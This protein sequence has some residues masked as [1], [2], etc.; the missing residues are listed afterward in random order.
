MSGVLLLSSL[1]LLAAGCRAPETPMAEAPAATS[2]EEP[3]RVDPAPPV[4]PLP[5]LLAAGEVRVTVEA[6]GVHLFA[7]EALLSHALAELAIAGAFDLE[8]EEGAYE[9]RRLT[10]RIDAVPLADVLALVLRGEAYRVSF[11]PDDATAGHR[12]A[13]VRVGT[14]PEPVASPIDLLLDHEEAVVVVAAIAA[15]AETGDST[16]VAALE[17][18]LAD[19][20][21]EVREAALAAIEELEVLA[22]EE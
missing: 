22:E 7:N 8:A 9:D 4:M 6:A 2:V 17:P 19:E 21:G 16:A 20:D 11:R 3:A 10:A 5:E 18:L 13:S 1:L 12:V 15:L 14:P